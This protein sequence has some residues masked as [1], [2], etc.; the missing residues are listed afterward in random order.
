[1]GPSGHSVIMGKSVEKTPQLCLI[2]N[3]G[4]FYSAFLSGWSASL[5]VI[6]RIYKKL[7]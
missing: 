6:D 5:S 4:S 1:M 7:L 2:L 3:F